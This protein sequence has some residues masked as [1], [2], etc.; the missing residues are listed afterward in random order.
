MSQIEI[1]SFLGCLLCYGFRAPNVQYGRHSFGVTGLIDDPHIGAVWYAEPHLT[2]AVN[3]EGK[4]VQVKG[5]FRHKNCHRLSMSAVPFPD[6]TCSM[7]ALIPLETDF[8]LRV[9]RE[10]YALVKRGYHSTAGRIQLGYLFAIE[11]NRHTMKL[12]K[13]FRLQK[14]HYCH[15]RIRIVQLKAKRPTMRESAQN[16]C[17]DN[18]LTKFCNNIITAHRVGAFGGKDALWDFLKDVAQNLNRKNVGNRYFENTKCFAQAM[19]IYGGRRLGDLFALNYAG[20]SYDTIRRDS[21]KGVLFILGEHADIFSSIASIYT[22][23][24]A[25]HGI[26]GPIPVILA[27]DETKVCGR[28][29]WEART[30]TMLGFCGPKESHTCI[31]DYKPKVGD[32]HEGYNKLM[33][34]FK[35]NKVG[36]FARVIVVNPLHEKLPRLVLAARCTCGSFDSAWVRA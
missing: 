27:E 32:G 20:P 17:A 9:R 25:V 22:D 19:R 18:N 14:L 36:G 23:A 24:K 21:R 31:A 1:Q 8:R 15:A 2:A 28:I 7:C 10:E 4:L 29:S 11:V 12:S 30:D 3:L 33:E 34:S 13:K 6:L 26:S 35:L 5:A 16:A